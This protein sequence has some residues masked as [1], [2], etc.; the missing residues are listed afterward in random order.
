MSAMVVQEAVALPPYVRVHISE[1][2]RTYFRFEASTKMRSNK[3]PISSLPLGTDLAAAIDKYNREV[4]PHLD[5]WRQNRLIAPIQDGPLYA[6]LSWASE[7]YKKTIRY[8]HLAEITK[9]TNDRAIVRTCRHV[10][11]SGIFAGQRF[12]DVP[13]SELTPALADQFYEEYLVTKTD[14]DGKTSYKERSPLARNDIRILRTMLNAI[15]RKHGRLFH[16]ENPFKGIFMPHKAKGPAAVNL[17]QLATFVRTADMMGLSSISAI[18]LYAWEMQ[19][20]VSHFPFEAKV[21]HYRPEGH[22]DEI[23]VRAEKVGDERYFRLFDDDYE[24]L[25][26]ALIQRLDALKRNRT[27]GPLFVCEQSASGHPEA[28]K[29][30]DL[31][32]AIAGICKAAGLPNLTLTQFRT[33]GLTEAGAAGL[34]TTQIMSQSMH[35]NEQTVQIYIEK[36]Q[37]VTLQGQTLR[38]KWRR[39]KARRGIDI[40]T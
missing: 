3:F 40:V 29:C 35:K 15:N 38:L 19:A 25:Y 5:D 10:I 31:R 30:D 6:T 16:N 20:R 17:L 24:P 23:L 18:V 33:G 13:L 12:G 26:P 37:E 28:W 7:T 9:K 22:G 4:L 21:E 14:K 32:K 27:S 2:G 8:Q 1:R 11:Q 39:N 34:T 36:N